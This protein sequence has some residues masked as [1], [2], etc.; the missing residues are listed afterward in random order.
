MID[1][2]YI[3]QLIA[4]KLEGTSLFLVEARVSADQSIRV[5]IDSPEGVRI[6][7]CIDLSRHIEGNLDRET[8]DFSL[9]VSS[10]GLDLPLRVPQ[11]YSKN[12]GRSVSVV[13]ASGELVEGQIVDANENGF[14][15]QPKAPKK[16]KKKDAVLVEIAPLW[17]PYTD[18]KETK[19]ILTF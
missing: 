6:E 16:S 3:L 4:E 18:Q 12:V 2:N 1:K 15:L 7:D 14:S 11:Q 13:M 19:I 8:E 5:F 9:D 17:I 10:A